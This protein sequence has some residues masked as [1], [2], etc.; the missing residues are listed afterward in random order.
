VPAPLANRV[1]TGGL[2]A[3]IFSTSGSDT[4]ETLMPPVFE[5]TPSGQVRRVIAQ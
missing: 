2:R 1:T 4:W 5:I 3:T